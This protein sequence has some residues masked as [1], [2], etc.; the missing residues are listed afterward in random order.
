[1]A[2]TR[3]IVAGLAAS[4]IFCGAAGAQTSLFDQKPAGGT[5]PVEAPP[6]PAAAKPKPKPRGPAPARALSISNNSGSALTDFVVAAEGKQA[7][8]ARELGTGETATLRLPAF[9][10]C[11]VTIIATFE[12]AGEAEQMEQN[13]CKDRKVRLTN[14]GGGET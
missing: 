2:L 1:M 6:A 14:M 8:L 3:R 5:A 7:K 12:R 10:T 11:M 4:L 13:I 9:K